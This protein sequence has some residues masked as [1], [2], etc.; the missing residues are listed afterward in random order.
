M[1]A[2]F[3]GLPRHLRLAFPLFSGAP[4]TE[5]ITFSEEKTSS[6]DFIVLRDYSYSTNFSTTLFFLSDRSVLSHSVLFGTVVRV[7]S[8]PSGNV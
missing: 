8:C 7:V 3:D 1:F 2:S 6:R 5:H 4:R